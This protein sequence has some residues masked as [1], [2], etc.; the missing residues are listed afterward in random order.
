MPKTPKVKTAKPTP[1]PKKADAS[2]KAPMV[3]PKVPRKS[4]VIKSSNHNLPTIT[5]DDE[6]DIEALKALRHRKDN[7]NCVD[8]VFNGAFKRQ[9]NFGGFEFTISND[10]VER[11]GQVIEALDWDPSEGKSCVADDSFTGHGFIKGK[12]SKEY[13]DSFGVSGEDIAIPRKGDLVRV[14]GKL[15]VSS[16]KGVEYCYLQINNMIHILEDAE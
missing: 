12:L 8:I 11:I 5:G 14:E 7:D 3:K 9:N 16:I 6:E 10:E 2:P 15:M 13:K 4:P 1:T